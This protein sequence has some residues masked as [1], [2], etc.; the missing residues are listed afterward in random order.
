MPQRYAAEWSRGKTQS[1]W[2]GEVSLITWSLHAPWK[3]PCWWWYRRLGETQS[4]Y[5]HFAEEETF[6]PVV[7]KITIPKMSCL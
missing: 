6:A 5:G 2:R 3:R 1:W 7:T 4:Q